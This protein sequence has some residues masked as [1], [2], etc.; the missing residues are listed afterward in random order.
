MARITPPGYK[1]ERL[2]VALPNPTRKWAS[3]PLTVPA[4]KWVFGCSSVSGAMIAGYY[5]RNGYP[6]H[7]YRADRWRGHAIG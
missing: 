4:F 3:T 1:L 5:D 2:A 7:V 6:E